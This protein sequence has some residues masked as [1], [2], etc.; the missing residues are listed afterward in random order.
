MG[1]SRFELWVSDGV[2]RHCASVLWPAMATAINQSQ[3]EWL[4]NLANLI[5]V[6]SRYFY[7]IKSYFSI[8]RFNQ[9]NVQHDRTRAK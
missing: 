3:T 7:R 4:R 2:L 6:H 9:K 5:H 8:D 1:V